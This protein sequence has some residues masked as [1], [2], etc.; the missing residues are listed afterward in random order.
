MWYAASKPFVKSHIFGDTKYSAL[1]WAWIALRYLSSHYSSILVYR[2][3]HLQHRSL[4]LSTAVF[5]TR[6]EKLI[7]LSRK[8]FPVKLRP[9]AP[10]VAIFSKMARSLACV[11]LPQIEFWRFGRPKL[12]SNEDYMALLG[13]IYLATNVQSM[14][15]TVCT[16]ISSLQ[17]KHI[18]K[19]FSTRCIIF[20]RKHC[21]S[22]LMQMRASCRSSAWCMHEPGPFDHLLF[23]S[24]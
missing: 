24:H 13:E 11:P 7:S 17:S 10:N 21:L 23:R 4:S 9:K 16:S 2:N 15:S 5:R 14:L 20:V 8:F 19:P 18:H 1:K 6:K 3:K 12:W 22:C